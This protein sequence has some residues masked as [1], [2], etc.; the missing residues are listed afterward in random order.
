MTPFAL[1]MSVPALA[2]AFTALLGALCYRDP[3]ARRH[4]EFTLIE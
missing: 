1:A 4:C 3:T 2:F